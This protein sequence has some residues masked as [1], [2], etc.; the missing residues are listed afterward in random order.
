MAYHLRNT[1]CT[2]N[3]HPSRLMACSHLSFQIKYRDS[4]IS[5]NHRVDA[6]AH[7]SPVSVGKV[8]HLAPRALPQLGSIQGSP[9]CSHVSLTSSQMVSHPSA[10]QSNKMCSIVLILPHL[11]HGAL[12]L[13]LSVIFGCSHLSP[14]MYLLW[15]DIQ[16]NCLHS[17][18][19]F[20]NLKEFHMASVVTSQHSSY[21][22]SS[23]CVFLCLPTSSGLS[24]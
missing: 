23:P 17:L 20:F 6:L 1:S 15:I 12:A 13:S 11:P 18:E 22:G 8:A 5:I 14:T 4:V 7:S 10:T 19:T 16:I 9:V 24:S 3:S 21:Q 2:V